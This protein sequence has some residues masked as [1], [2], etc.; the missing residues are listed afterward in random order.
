G[1]RGRSR[2]KPSP[3]CPRNVNQINVVAPGLDT[4]GAGPRPRK[5]PQRLKSTWQLGSGASESRGNAGLRYEGVA[6]RRPSRSLMQPRRRLDAVLG[7]APAARNPLD[8]GLD[9]SLDQSRQIVV[10]PGF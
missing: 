7:L 5:P 10:E 6:D 9:D 1:C 8:F 3:A 2:A 4:I